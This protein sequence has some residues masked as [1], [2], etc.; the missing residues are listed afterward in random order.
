MVTSG[1]TTDEA[2]SDFLSFFLHSWFSKFC[3]YLSTLYLSLLYNT[4][5]GVIS[6][7]GSCRTRGGAPTRPICP[8]CFST[9]RHSD[10]K[11]TGVEGTMT[12]LVSTEFL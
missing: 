1:L 3:F 4:P 7:L 9:V 12:V 6:F 2:E 11:S 5:L 8:V 10:G